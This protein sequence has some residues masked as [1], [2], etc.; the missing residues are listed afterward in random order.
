MVRH[1][2]LRGFYDVE[3]TIGCGGFAKVKL[4][5]HLATGEKVA[6]KIM[7]KSSLKDDLH[8]VKLELKALKSLSHKHICQLYEVSTWLVRVI[9]CLILINFA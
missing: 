6:I 8:R 5:T 9:V 1:S 3:R 4:A 2:V 7:N